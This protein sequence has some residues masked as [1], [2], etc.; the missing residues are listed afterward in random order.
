MLIDEEWKD[1]PN[2]NGN[3]KFIN[4]GICHVPQAQRWTFEGTMSKRLYLL[5]GLAATFVKKV[6]LEVY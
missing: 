4:Y 5:S 6:K 3:V 1:G 2:W